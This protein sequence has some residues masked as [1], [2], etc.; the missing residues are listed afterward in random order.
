MKNSAIVI[1]AL[2]FVSGAGLVTGCMHERVIQPPAVVSSGRA[3]IEVTEPPPAPI[4]ESIMISPGAGYVWIPGAWD[5]RGNAWV[6]EKGRWVIPPEPGS[7]WVPHRYE[8]RNGKH[9]FIPG[10]W[11]K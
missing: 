11:T 9:M 8:Y 4:A 6:W 2:S 7:Y 10:G 3:E 1:L 5:W